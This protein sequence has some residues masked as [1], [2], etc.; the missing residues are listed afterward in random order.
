M[1]LRPQSRKRKGRQTLRKTDMEPFRRANRQRRDNQA[2]RL[3][4]DHQCSWMRVER[5]ATFE[6]QRI[7]DCSYFSRFNQRVHVFSSPDFF[8]LCHTAFFSFFFL[9]KMLMCITNLAQC[10]ARVQ[11]HHSENGNLWELVMLLVSAENTSDTCVYVCGC[12]C[13][14]VCL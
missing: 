11:R 8:F 12:G 7:K 14:P 1:I 9:T 13:V 10:L 6:I 2:S 3:F 5:G 4:V